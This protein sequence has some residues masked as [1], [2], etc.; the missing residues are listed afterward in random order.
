M[1]HVEQCFSKRAVIGGRLKRTNMWGAAGDARRAAGRALNSGVCPKE[2]GTPDAF[3][4]RALGTQIHLW[5]R[6][7]L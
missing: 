2:E 4:T 3:A 6:A 5:D 1:R 7:Y